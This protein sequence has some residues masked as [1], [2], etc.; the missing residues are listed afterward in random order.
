MNDSQ[1]FQIALRLIEAAE[2]IALP[3]R[4]AA[5]PKTVPAGADLVATPEAAAH[6]QRVGGEDVDPYLG[7]TEEERIDDLLNKTIS[8]Y[9]PAPPPRDDGAAEG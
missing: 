9:E 3:A 1:R 7:K 8:T 4:G 2:R 5:P 6:W